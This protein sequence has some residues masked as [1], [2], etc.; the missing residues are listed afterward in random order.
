MFDKKGGL[1]LYEFFNFRNIVDYKIESEN[2]SV[3]RKSLFQSL[4]QGP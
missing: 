2:Q 3:I 4:I 1:T